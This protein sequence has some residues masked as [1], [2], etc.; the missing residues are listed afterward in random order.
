MLDELSSIFLPSNQQYFFKCSW[1]WVLMLWPLLQRLAAKERLH[2]KQWLQSERVLLSWPWKKGV[3][4]WGRKICSHVLT[5]LL[6]FVT[7][8]TEAFL[9]YTWL[10]AREKWHLLTRGYDQAQ[11]LTA[12]LIFRGFPPNLRIVRDATDGVLQD[13]RRLDIHSW[14]MTIEFLYHLQLVC[15]L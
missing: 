3:T 12:G 14:L 11:C 1:S 5:P 7:M 9:S 6:W 13:S 4:V 8:W 2:L 15:V 10:Q